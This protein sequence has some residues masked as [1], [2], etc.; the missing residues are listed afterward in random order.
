MGLS[1]NGSNSKLEWTGA[2]SPVS[3]YPITIAV[4]IKPNAATLA[5]ANAIGGIGNTTALEGLE[6]FISGADS[7]DPFQASSR[8]GGTGVWSAAALGIAQG[9]WQ[10][11]MAY[12]GGQSSRSARINGGT[13]VSGSETNAPLFTDFRRIVFGE[14]PSVAGGSPFNGDIARIAIWTSDRRGDFAALAAGALPSTISPA[15]LLD[16]LELNTLAASYV[17]AGTSGR[18]FTASNVTLSADHP[19]SSGDTTNPTLTGSITIGTV[20]S[21]SIQMIWPAGSDNVAVA[22]YDVSSDG[23]T[24]WTTL[25]NVLTHTFT[26][27]AASTTYQLRVRARDAAGNVSAALSAS[28]A[29]NAPAATPSLS[30]APIKNNTGTVLASTSIA[31]VAVLRLSDMASVLTLTNQTTSGAGV[32][33]ITNAA[34]TAATSYVVVLSNADGSALGT[35]RATAA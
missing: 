5:A 31:K 21:S 13:E 34:L 12:Y 25:G 32:L 18:T 29:T 20:T 3:T 1:F 26:G 28:Q 9:Q 6:L 7:G 15:T 23:G 30:S 2:S 14:R 4:W 17:S 11:C 24:S 33:T 22:G 10:L 27:L 35:F 8:A 19:A 16:Y